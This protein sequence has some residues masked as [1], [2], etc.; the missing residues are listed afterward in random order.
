M[1]S[2]RPGG[3]PTEDTVQKISSMMFFSDF[4]VSRPSYIKPDG[5]PREA[6]DLVALFDNQLLAFQVGSRAESAA[7]TS[8]KSEIELARI[9]RVVEKCVNQLNTTRRAIEN[10]W[11]QPLTT[12]RGLVLPRQ[13][14][15]TTPLTGIVVV[16][17][18]GESFLHPDERTRLRASF[19]FS[20]ATP[21][22]VFL[23]DEFVALA[24]ELDTMPDF[25]EFLGR[26]RFLYEKDLLAEPPFILD[27]LA[28]HKMDP[29]RLGDAISRGVRVE[30]ADGVWATYQQEQAVAIA[31]RQELNKP[32]YLIDGSIDTLHTGIDYSPPE[33]MLSSIGIV[34]KGSIE[35]Y[36]GIA[37]ELAS[38]PRLERRLLGERLVR[39]L[40]AAQ[41]QDYSSSVLFDQ[42]ASA[43]TLVLSTAMP[44]AQRQEFLYL[45]CAIAYCH[46]GLKK[47]VGIATEPLTGHGRSYDSIGFAGA[48][49][50]NAEALAAEAGKYFGQPYE[51]SGTEY[52]PGKSP[53]A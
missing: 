53:D 6:A 10:S 52:T 23:L 31:R 27:L 35:G 44:R 48:T 16:E 5:R 3:L 51:A 18:G 22:H 21:V 46:W 19:T 38:L 32:S 36:I 34:G 30:I 4:T 8:Y 1:T 25:L 39:C 42:P 47:I 13:P 28:L 2:N 29:D 49:F 11:L 20:R 33:S 14:S 12:I 7:G 26:V 9:T 15:M 50:S 41:S 40:K 37:H 24:K 45:L 43:A 17:V